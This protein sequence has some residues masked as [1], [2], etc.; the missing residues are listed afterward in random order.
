MTMIRMRRVME[1]PRR[2]MR[3]RGVVI[4]G[5]CRGSVRV[6]GCASMLSLCLLC[7]RSHRRTGVVLG[8]LV[9]GKGSMYE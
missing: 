8:A 4:A 3:C 2:Y 6:Y 7:T 1:P 9:G 5:C